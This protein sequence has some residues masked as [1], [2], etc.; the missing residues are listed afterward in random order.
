VPGRTS[1][2]TL[3]ADC[4]GH[5][6]DLVGKVKSGGAVKADPRCPETG[7]R[8]LK[9]KEGIEASGGLITRS[10]ASDRCPEEHPEGEAVGS[11]VVGATRRQEKADND[12][13]GRVAD[14][15]TQAGQREQTPGW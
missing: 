4:Q 12:R 8:G 6:Q 5:T 3:E 14:E 2:E 11:G 9:T 1:I 7:P 13:R 10:V 15:A